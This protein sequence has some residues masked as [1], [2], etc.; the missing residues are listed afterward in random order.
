MLIAIG[1]KKLREEINKEI[2]Q[3]QIMFGDFQ[4]KSKEEDVSLGVVISARGLEASI[5]ATIIKGLAKRR[6]KYLK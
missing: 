5:E 3:N 2:K 4:V 1:T 6:E